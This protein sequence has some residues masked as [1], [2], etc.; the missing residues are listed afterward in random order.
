MIG[1]TLLVAGR[2]LG[3]ITNAYGFFSLTL[4]IGI[5]QISLSHIGYHAQDLTVSL[6]Y[7]QQLNLR[8]EPAAHQLKQIVITAPPTDKKD[9]GESNAHTIG[10]QEVKD[11][12]ALFGE[13]DIMQ[14]IQ[15]LPGVLSTGESSGGFS[16]RGGTSDQNLILLDE[17]PIYNVSHLLGIFSV[18]NPDAIKQVKLYKGS[19]PTEYR[20]RL[21]SVL[22]IRMQDGNTERWGVSGGIGLIASRLK[23]EGKLV[24]DKSSFMIAG[25]RTYYDWLIKLFSGQISSNAA[26]FFSDVN[27]KVNWKFSNKDRI[28]LSGYYG[29]DA[30]RLD[31]Q[32]Q[33]EWGNSTATLRWNHLFNDQLF[34]NT[35][36][37]FNDYEFTSVANVQEVLGNDITENY[38]VRTQIRDFNLKSKFEYFPD[39]NNEVKFGLNATYH[40]FT[41]G[42]SAG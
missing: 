16:V 30:L 21:S 5:Y 28:Y 31:K 8:L 14:G 32:N 7:N 29:K 10:M 40:N 26:F 20:G 25:R 35:S 38:S 24:K 17:A 33:V 2:S 13:Q 27:A 9:P 15:L 22:D 1:S 18:F 36:L 34:V 37:I 39:P 11:I 41:P 3:T 4:P 19:I 6:N 23:L 12:P 42:K